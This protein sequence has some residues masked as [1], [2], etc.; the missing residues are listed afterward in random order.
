MNDG[1]I[2]I[3]FRIGVNIK[4][5]VGEWIKVIIIIFSEIEGWINTEDITRE[6]KG[7]KIIKYFDTI[8]NNKIIIKI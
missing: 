7:I 2:E 4:E 5:K 1:I 8:I 3:F 6:V